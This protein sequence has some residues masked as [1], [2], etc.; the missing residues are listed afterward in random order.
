VKQELPGF[1]KQ[2][3]GDHER[4]S[5]KLTK[6]EREAFQY[7]EKVEKCVAMFLDL[8]R[9]LTWA[10]IA[11]ELKISVPS[12]HNLT[13]SELFNEK[14]NEYFSE[15]GHDPRIKVS[16]QALADMVPLAVRTLR[17]ILID[18]EASSASRLK[19]VEQ[20]FRMAGVESISQKQSD[21]SELQKFLL[22]KG[23]KVDNIDVSV[24]LSP[25]QA[26][27]NRM[28]ANPPPIV[29]DGVFEDCEA[30]SQDDEL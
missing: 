3:S 5:I 28:L 16:Q 8:N 17:E 24:Q 19:A 22:E 14:Y 23:I 1:I 13:K 15:L 18:P 4:R 7:R 20:V 25:V 21:K 6:D 11:K 26:R 9:E 12:L 27:A 29:V 2:R 10:Q 30:Q